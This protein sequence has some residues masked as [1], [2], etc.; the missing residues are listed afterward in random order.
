MAH[1][2]PRWRGPAARH[3]AE[4]LRGN[5]L[6]PWVAGPSCCVVAFYHLLFFQGLATCP[7]EVHVV[8]SDE[9]DVHVLFEC[10]VRVSTK[11]NEASEQ[12][13]YLH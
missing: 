11:E 12:A 6:S 2:N 1:P 3:L 4:L 10:G 9:S 5:F 7:E 13:W 8:G